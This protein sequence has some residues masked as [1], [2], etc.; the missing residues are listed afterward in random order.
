MIW[1]R[2]QNR[3]VVKQKNRRTF[4]AVK[5]GFIDLQMSSLDKTAGFYHSQTH[6][7]LQVVLL[8][9]LKNYRR[10]ANFVALVRSKTASKNNKSFRLQ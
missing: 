3:T 4:S 2:F 7:E 8:R 1:M 10:K 5:T 9:P 6:L